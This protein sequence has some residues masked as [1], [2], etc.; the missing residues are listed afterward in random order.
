MHIVSSFGQFLF[1]PFSFLLLCKLPV[2]FNKR[3]DLQGRK[4][5]IR[6]NR[7]ST[8]LKHLSKNIPQQDHRNQI[9]QHLGDHQFHKCEFSNKIIYHHSV[10]FLQ[11]DSLVL[12]MHHLLKN[13]QL[14]WFRQGSKGRNAA[15]FHSVISKGRCP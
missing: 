5:S 11:Q 1:L 4:T 9:S 7:V 2:V 3:I 14:H 8:W 6:D 12:A 13:K 15:F 10:P